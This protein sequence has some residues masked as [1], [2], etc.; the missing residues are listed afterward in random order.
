MINGL[1]VMECN[2]KHIQ[3]TFYEKRRISPRRKAFWDNTFMDTDWKKAW[4]LP[5]KYRIS[6]KI[7]ESHLKILHTIYPTNFK[8]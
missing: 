2:N 5:Y 3:N 7:K 1:D 4:I 6:N 8:Y